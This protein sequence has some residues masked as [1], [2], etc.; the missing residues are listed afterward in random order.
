MPKKCFKYLILLIKRVL[1]GKHHKAVSLCALLAHFSELKRSGI[2]E[3]SM[4]PVFF[5]SETA[6]KR[7]KTQKSCFK[8]QKRGEKNGRIDK[9]SK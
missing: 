4:E 9:R 1:S 5:P 8:L 6:K 3:L 7:R 2:M